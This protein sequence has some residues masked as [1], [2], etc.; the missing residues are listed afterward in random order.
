M[1]PGCLVLTAPNWEPG[2]QSL[3]PCCQL[4][5]NGNLASDGGKGQGKTVST[6]GSWV[7]VFLKK[8]VQTHTSLI[9]DLQNLYPETSPGQAQARYL[10]RCQQETLATEGSTGLVFRVYWG[11]SRMNQPK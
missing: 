11:Q 9:H 5:E 10:E 6:A 7:P 2:A 1:G 8:N 3:E 4:Q